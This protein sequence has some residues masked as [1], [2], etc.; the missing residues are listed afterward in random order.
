MR[1]SG[2]KRYCQDLVCN[3][4]GVDGGEREEWKVTLNFLAQS[5]QN[6]KEN[7]STDRL[8]QNPEEDYEYSR[9]NFEFQ[10]LVT[11]KLKRVI[12]KG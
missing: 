1:E 12:R 4:F 8:R 3:S 10:V 7:S 9:G 6:D 5:C 2:Q 11:P